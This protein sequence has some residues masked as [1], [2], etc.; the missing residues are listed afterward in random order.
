VDG[1]ASELQA[2]TIVVG[3][4]VTREVREHG[5]RVGFQI[6]DFAGGRAMMAHIGWTTGCPVGRYRVDVTAFDS[7]ATPAIEQALSAADVIILD[8][9]G[10]MEL[11]SRTFGRA[12][13][14]LFTATAP[15][16]L[17]IH[18]QHRHARRARR[19]RRDRQQRGLPDA[20]IA[21]QDERPAL[22]ANPGDELIEQRNLGLAAKQP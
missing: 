3:G 15:L 7:I 22:L 14:E 1:L 19:A 9:I 11:C 8:E 10:Q 12:I 20:G 5:E 17:T 18:A 4:F 6:E 2:A 21:A 13:G 16:V